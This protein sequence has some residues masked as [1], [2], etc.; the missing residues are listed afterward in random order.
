LIERNTITGNVRRPS[1]AVNTKNIL[2]PF[3]S[4]GQ[5]AMPVRVLPYGGIVLAVAGDG[6]D[7]RDNDIVRNAFS[8]DLGLTPLRQL[9]QNGVF[10]LCGD[11]VVITGNR[12]ADNGRRSVGVQPL[13]GVRAGVAVLLAGTADISPSVDFEDLT[14]PS[15][16]DGNHP[17]VALEITKNTI[18]HPEGRALAAVGI[19]PMIVDG[20]YLAARGSEEI[21][22]GTDYSV[23]DVVFLVNFAAPR[24]SLNPP[25]PGAGPEFAGYDGPSGVRDYLIPSGDEAPRF[26]SV[27]GTVHF[28]NN[29]VT[30]DW[31][32]QHQPTSTNLFTFAPVTLFTLDHLSL[33]SNQ[34][35][36][37]F[38]DSEISGVVSPALS[39]D[40]P[41]PIAAN[42]FAGGGT[43]HAI[44]NR[45]S[46]QVGTV[47][48]S[49]FSSGE[50]MNVTAHNQSTHQVFAHRFRD[51]TSPT[52]LVDEGNQVLFKLAT[53]E[54]PNGDVIAAFRQFF[55]MLFNP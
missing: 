36:L 8:G 10:I 38:D 33:C 6:C 26:I 32:V 18:R 19:G 17:G 22:N 4:P 23:G 42:V 55:G 9:P 5:S 34:F 28:N 1:S 14:S 39:P 47:F 7:I 25:T 12:I 43:I 53:P 50:L 27:G 2:Q 48:L 30:Y 37:R 52:H 49:L 29:Q 3:A 11:G 24:E 21:G 31:A 15:P 20:N 13:S 16:V 35:V 51:D 40:R 41:E 46:E 45:F 44:R 54:A